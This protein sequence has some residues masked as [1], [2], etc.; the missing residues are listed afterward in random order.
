M[1]LSII[2]EDL[3]L[4][5]VVGAKCFTENIVQ[6]REQVEVMIGDDDFG[7]GRN[8]TV[9]DKVKTRTQVEAQFFWFISFKRRRSRLM[10]EKSGF[11]APSASSLN[12][13][14]QRTDLLRRSHGFETMDRGFNNSFLGHPTFSSSPDQS[15]R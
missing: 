2:I 13:E 1:P 3:F 14:P 8:R 10:S 15:D 11:F 5:K 12:Q 9:Q 6:I 7:A 4:A